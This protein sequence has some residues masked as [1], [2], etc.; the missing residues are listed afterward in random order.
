MATALDVDRIRVTAFSLAYKRAASPKTP[1]AAAPATM[2]TPVGCAAP[3]VLFTD[4][5]GLCEAEVEPEEVELEP[6]EAE[7]EPEEVKLEFLEAELVI[8]LE[9]MLV[10]MLVLMLMLDVTPLVL[11]VVGAAAFTSALKSPFNT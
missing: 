10:L 8:M 4:A 3:P 7:V 9:L 1:A 11:T 6:E 2:M 5:G